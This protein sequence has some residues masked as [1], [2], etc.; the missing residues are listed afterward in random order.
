M[1]G[2]GKNTK[3]RQ[4][5]QINAKRTEKYKTQP[6]KAEINA[7]RREKYKTQAEVKKGTFKSYPEA[8]E[9][10]NNAKENKNHSSQPNVQKGNT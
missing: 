4:I 3:L 7:N 8:N 2:G 1:Q 5:K 10:E 6:K 9:V